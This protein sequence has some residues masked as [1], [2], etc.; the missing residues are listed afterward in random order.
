MKTILVAIGF[1][2]CLNLPANGQQISD[3]YSIGK[4]YF[5][6]SSAKDQTQVMS[7]ELTLFDNSGPYYP[8][9]KGAQ[10]LDLFLIHEYGGRTLK[11]T[12][13]TIRLSFESR[14]NLS[15][16]KDPGT[17]TF[18][19]TVDGRTIV[20][21]ALTLDSST[22]IGF[23]TWENLSYDLSL[24]KANE[25]IAAKKSATITLGKITHYLTKTELAVFE[26]FLNAL[27]T[28]NST[29]WRDPDQACSLLSD[30]G[31]RME[32][33]KY[34]GLNTFGCRAPA[35]PFPRGSSNTISFRPEGNQKEITELILVLQV[36]SDKPIALASHEAFAIVCGALALRSLGLELPNLLLLAAFAGNPYTWQVGSSTV[37]LS[38]SLRAPDGSYEVRFTIK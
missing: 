26:D 17:G 7:K 29:G 28:G 20:Q 30:I 37:E 14:S 6:Y 18:E 2:L 12:P 3:V 15:H 16:Y 4:T 8:F 31:F 21:A 5:A 11:Q 25:L 10:R 22:P 9:V 36:T 34:V 1:T 19:L 13:P 24:A 38:P 32:P 23:V 35:V 27:R 33:Y